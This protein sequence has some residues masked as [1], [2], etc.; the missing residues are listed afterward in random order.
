MTERLE[1][2]LRQEPFVPFRVI[3]TSGNSYDVTSPLMVAIGRTELSYYY[4]KSD[5][6]AHLRLN[7]L[8]ALETLG[9]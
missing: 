5:K 3:L 9:V 7:Q 1:E 4:P 6:L 8:A 2:L